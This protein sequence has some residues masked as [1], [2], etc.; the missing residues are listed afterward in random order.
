M[1]QRFLIASLIAT[2]LVASPAA[3]CPA[4]PP[5]VRDLS[6]TR[7]YADDAGSVVD[8][9]KQDQHK[10][11]TA[12][13]TAFVGFIAKQADKAYRQRSSPAET[14]ACAIVWIKGWAMSGAYLGT[15]D[16]KQAEAQRRW[17]LAG[18][19]LAYLKLKQWATADD[20]AA[21][22]PWLIKVAD[23]ARAAFGDAGVK[24]NNHWYWMGL[25][26]GAV[27]IAAESGTHWQLAKE[28]MQ[29]AA[30]DISAEGTL[31]LELARG[32]RALHYHAFAVM[33][34]VTLAELSVSRNENFYALAD[35]A[36]HRLVA[37]TARG[38]AD[39]VVFDKLAGVAQERPVNPGAGWASLYRARFPDRLKS[40]SQQ[41]DTH[42]WL[43]G[44][45]GVLREVL[46]NRQ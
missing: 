27:G 12:P 4:P 5:L 13:L 6:L 45:V 33:P 35:A 31:P 46:G 42:R 7:F 1:L 32:A 17:D 2:A 9:K 38:L 24:R 29:D 30:R 26:L 25:G 14:A 44:D 34:L 39:P 36:L 3:A 15:I 21:I 11:A 10:T 22:E 23:A 37:M 8:P 41:S 28:I 18:I 40:P 16:G 20:R 43:G 19:A